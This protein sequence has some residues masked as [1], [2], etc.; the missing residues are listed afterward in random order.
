MHERGTEQ[1]NWDLWDLSGSGDWTGT[2]S[3]AWGGLTFLKKKKNPFPLLCPIYPG[4]VTRLSYP[5]ATVTNHLALQAVSAQ[6]Q[7][8]QLLTGTISS[9]LWMVTSKEANVD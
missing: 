9:P 2:P 6:P 5:E 1:T 4:L 8:P 3:A 7:L